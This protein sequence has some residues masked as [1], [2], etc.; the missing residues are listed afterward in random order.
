MKNWSKWPEVYDL[1]F[2]TYEWEEKDA[3]AGADYKKVKTTKPLFLL[4]IGKQE[5][6]TTAMPRPIDQT[7]SSI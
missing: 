1:F 4:K 3:G 2:V 6:Y 5:R 7:G